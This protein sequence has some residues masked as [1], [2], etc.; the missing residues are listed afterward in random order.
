MSILKKLIFE[1]L[2]DL[3]NA[4]Y[5]PKKII[6]FRNKNYPDS[7]YIIS[8]SNDIND[9]F[10]KVMVMDRLNN[11]FSYMMQKVKRNIGLEIIAVDPNAD[12]GKEEYT[13][14]YNLGRYLLA[15][16]IAMNIYIFNPTDDFAKEAKSFILKM[17][18]TYKDSNLLDLI[19]TINDVIKAN[20]NYREQNGL[21][22]TNIKTL[23]QHQID[24]SNKPKRGRPKKDDNK[25]DIKTF[26]RNIQFNI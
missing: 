3:N 18:K 17:F 16:P 7:K 13:D 10:E 8:D 12:K 19:P 1:S 5:Q 25:K 2:R 22:N 26:D 21:I 4:T 9:E 20:K 14:L 24:T 15:N 6:E 23:Q 11:T